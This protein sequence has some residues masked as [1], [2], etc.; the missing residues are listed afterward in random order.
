MS[1]TSPLPVPYPPYEASHVAGSTAHRAS[2]GQGESI[3]GPPTTVQS[4]VSKASDLALSHV[5]GCG[6]SQ[7]RVLWIQDPSF[8]ELPQA[9]LFDQAEGRIQAASPPSLSVVGTGSVGVIPSHVSLPQPYPFC[10]TQA[11][12]V[13]YA[14][15][16]GSRSINIWT[17][18]SGRSTL[19]TH[20]L[21]HSTQDAFRTHASLPSRPTSSRPSCTCPQ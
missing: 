18:S 15:T 2:A 7:R 1:D 17:A 3:Q 21:A 19:C 9:N 20:R 6:A 5:P 14:G 4:D 12:P 8:L 10:R 11:G 13:P 16:P